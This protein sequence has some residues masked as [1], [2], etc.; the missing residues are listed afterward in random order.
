MSA[1]N[2]PQLIEAVSAIDG[3]ASMNVPLRIT[4]LKEELAYVVADESDRVAPG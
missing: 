1:R 3:L 2:H 4:E